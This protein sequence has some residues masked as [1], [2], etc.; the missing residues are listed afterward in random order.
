MEPISAAIEREGRVHPRQPVTELTQRDRPFTFT[1]MGYLDSP[2][3]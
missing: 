2:L 3:A 1:P